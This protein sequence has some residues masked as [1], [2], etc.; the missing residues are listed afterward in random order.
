MYFCA[1]NG[2][3]ST[4][5]AN[6]TSASGWETFDI[7]VHADNTVNLKTYN[8]FFL[9]IDGTSSSALIATAEVA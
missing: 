8:G 1:E 3:G 6:R 9:G 7:T 5:I 2:G 4:I